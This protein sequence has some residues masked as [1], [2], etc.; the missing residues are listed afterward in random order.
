MCGVPVLD[1]T[2]RARRLLDQRRDSH[3]A[4]AGHADRKIDGCAHSRS[5]LPSLADGSKMRGEDERGTTGIR[6]GDH[7]DVG[8]GKRRAWIGFGD[9]WIVPT[10]YLAQEYTGIGLA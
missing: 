3:R 8:T 1:I 7:R 6:L 2:N 10:R 4:L 9:K 5:V